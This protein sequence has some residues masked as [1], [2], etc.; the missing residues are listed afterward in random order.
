MDL[1]FSRCRLVPITL[2]DGSSAMSGVKDHAKIGVK[3]LLT[4]PYFALFDEMGNMKSAQAIIAAQ[5]L[6]TRGIIDRVIVVAP[7]SVR[8]GVWYDP[9]LGELARHLWNDLPSKI[10]EY[11]SRIRSWTHGPEVDSADK[12]LRWIVTNYEFIRPTDRLKGK[13]AKA[14]HQNVS[15]LFPYCGPKTLLILDESSAIKS[16]KSAQTKACMQLRE[17]CG[18]VVLLNGTPIAN[19]P[20]D[21]FSQGNMMS[22]SILKCPSYTQFCGRYAIMKAVL[23]PG[24]KIIKK[25]NYTVSTVDKWT[26]IDDIQKRFAPYVLRR[27]KSECLDLPAKLPVVVLTVELVGP[28]WTMYKQMRDEL[29]VWLSTC[30]V[31]QAPQAMTKV[32]RLA[33]ITSGFLGGV[34][35]IDFG[36]DTLFADDELAPVPDYIASYGSLDQ[37]GIRRRPPVAPAQEVGSE[38]QDLFMDWL[39]ERWKEDPNLKVIVR[40]RFRPEALRLG[41]ALKAKGKCDVGLII[42]GQTRQDRADSLRMLDPRTAPKGPAVGIMTIGTGSLGL[43]FTASHTMFTLSNDFSLHHRLQSDDRVHR[44]GQTSAVSYFDLVA[45]GPQG[46]KT[47]DHKVL[48]A[49]T[50][51]H[52]LANLTTSAWLDVLKSTDD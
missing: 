20:G 26:G 31:S 39:D 35:D 23:G 17:K 28:R 21:M 12:R 16:A 4:H 25:G 46:Q 52:D 13:N 42:G 18:R 44:P 34:E 36:A 49:L 29:V 38:K 10:S 45:T 40:S 14:K 3:A 43:N 27:L 24:G 19:G 2:P 30:T 6:F 1:D 51:K 47:I 41:E 8:T 22:K 37:I 50:A 32:M 11:H 7:S 9:E 15:V 48:A 33:Q 5:F